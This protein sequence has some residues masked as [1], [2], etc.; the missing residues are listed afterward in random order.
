MAFSG[1]GG[2]HADRALMREPVAITHSL[3]LADWPKGRNAADEKSMADFFREVEEDIRRDRVIKFWSKYQYV[4]IA[5]IILAI[6][7]TAAWRIVKTSREAAAERAGARFEE[8][9]SLSREGKSVEAEAAL[10]ALAKDGPK[11]YAELARL[12]GADELVK[13][14]PDAAIKAYDALI[15]DKDV[16]Q[17]FRD[18]A[19]L[20]A[21]YL[22]IDREDPKVFE[23]HHAAYASGN[24]AYK[25]SMRELLAL[26]ALKRGDYE[27]AGHWLDGII[28]DQYAPNA[29]RMRAGA[30]ISLVQSAKAPQAKPDEAKTPESK[31]PEANAAEA[32]PAAEATADTKAPVE[33]ETAPKPEAANPSPGQKQP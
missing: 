14:D 3:V 17:D 15:A 2:L 6:A 18:T 10:Q 28:A 30:L 12:R 25:N 29:L 11:G 8:A 7:G 5:L 24:F 19:R 31:A 9:L 23:Y 16:D 13:R 4:I 27:G 22:R 32:K 1:A 33:T 26:A 21:A 20:R